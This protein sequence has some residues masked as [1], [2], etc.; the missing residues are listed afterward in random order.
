VGSRSSIVSE[1]PLS[2]IIVSFNCR[3]LLA[4]CLDSLESHRSDV[5]LDVIVVDNGSTDGTAEVARRP[6]VRLI[7]VG[8]NAGFAAANNL[9]I[10]RA[11]GRFL[12]FLNPDTIVPPGALRSLVEAFEARPEIGMLGCKLT[13]PGGGLDHAAK[14]GFPSPA[15][16]LAYFTGL[17][18]LRPGS[19]RL[20]QYTAGH[21]DPD[22]EHRVDA[23]NGAM[24]LVRREALADVGPMDEDYWLYM[25][26]LDWCYRFWRAGWPVLYWPGVEIVH[27]KGGSS[28]KT[29]AWTTNYHFHRGM[30]LFYRKHYATK[31]SLG[32]NAM[33]WAGVWSKLAVSASRSLVIRSMSR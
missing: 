28:G 27:V 9:A 4:Q 7:E 16:A 24:M 31:R 10:P 29:R 26:D 6:N 21:L 17:S 11:R 19:T 18:R 22:E 33:V 2:I 32:M 1:P 12:L 30:W 23:I 25:E 8:S 20:A 3:S 15:A 5:D 14:R 13:L